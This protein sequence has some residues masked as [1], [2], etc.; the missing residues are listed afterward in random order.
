[1][2]QTLFIVLLNINTTNLLLYIF[3]GFFQII[4]II[5]FCKFIY[6][7]NIKIN[8][9]K[10]YFILGR[11]SEGSIYS[12]AIWTWHRVKRFEINGSP[13]V[14]LFHHRTKP[15]WRYLGLILWRLLRS[16]KTNIDCVLLRFICYNTYKNTRL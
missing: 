16:T 7:K 5:W 15:L 1:M 4:T 11:K 10:I 6:S 12:D 8:K 14:I 9:F 2:N 13:C 3:L